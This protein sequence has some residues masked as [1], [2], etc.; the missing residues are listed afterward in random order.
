MF[1]VQ[2]V[3]GSA[4]QRNIVSERLDVCLLC[5]PSHSSHTSLRHTD[6]ISSFLVSSPAITSVYAPAGSLSTASDPSM[7]ASLS[8]DMTCSLYVLITA[9]SVGDLHHFKKCNV[10]FDM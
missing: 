8:G 7:Y 10:M 6:T 5:K 4:K 3:E 1:D 2:A 9:F